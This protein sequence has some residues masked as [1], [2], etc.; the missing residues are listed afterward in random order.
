[1]TLTR[2]N[3]AQ[4]A[5]HTGARVLH[6]LDTIDR[7]T[8][9]A[10]RKSGLGGSDAAAILG[11]SP[12]TSSY[13][14]WLDKTSTG[15][16]GDQSTLAQRRGTFLEDFILAEAMTVDPDLQVHRAP[17]MLG[18][19]VHPHLFANLD[20]LATHERRRGWGGAEAKNVNAFQRHEWDNGPPAYYEAQVG[21]YLGR[22]PNLAWWVVIA[23]F[24][25]DDLRTFYID[26]DDV[27]VDTITERELAWWERHIIGGEEPTID[28]HPAT[29]ELL[30][31]TPADPGAV[32]IIQ[33][34]T[35]VEQV[36]WRIAT[37]K[38]AAETLAADE[39]A[40]KNEL[41]LLL[42]EATELVDEAGRTW[43]TWRTSKPKAV[44]DWRAVAVDLAHELAER[45]DAAVAQR[46]LGAAAD[47]TTTKP[48]NRSLLTAP[49][50][51]LIKEP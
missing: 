46:L 51:K 25:G 30:M 31:A 3:A 45:G 26:R 49:G 29:T 17:Y 12:W 19:P 6:D 5:A 13:T 8:W 47:H 33:D 32:Q 37:I 1:M 40:A 35:A 10:Y 18:D 28:G 2:L 43:A 7:P 41:R 16:P 24:G 9:L 14:L 44:T 11:V 38:A 22:C 27:P 42:G 48:G 20:G 4:V 23:D 50:L 36:F 34:P 15:S 21:H 39:D